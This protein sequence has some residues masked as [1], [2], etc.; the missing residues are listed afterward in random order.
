VNK[1]LE[2]FIASYLSVEVAYDGIEAGIRDTIQSFGPAFASALKEG[3]EELLA[4]REL[5][6][7]D[8][9][10]ITYI[11]FESDEALYEYLQGMY[12]FFFN[13]A[14]TPPKPPE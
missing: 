3:F 9:D 10:G 4:T 6:K 7:W 2:G 8:Y 12:D 14:E 11:E 5:S 13:G 1:T